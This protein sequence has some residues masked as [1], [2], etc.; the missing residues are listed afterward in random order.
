MHKHDKSGVLD[1]AILRYVEAH[2]HAADTVAGVRKWW[3]ADDVPVA[4]A[5]AVERALERLA[6]RGCLRRSVL[7]EGTVLYS[8]RGADKG[9]GCAEGGS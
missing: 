7:R 9:D 3:L 5:S 8:G 4:S 2:P 6:A 1:R